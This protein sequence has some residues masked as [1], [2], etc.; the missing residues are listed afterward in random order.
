MFSF[1]QPP[2]LYRQSGLAL[3]LVL[4]QCW[5]VCMPPF[6][7]GIWVQTEPTICFLY[8]CAC[9][10]ALWLGVGAFKGWLTPAQG[11]TPL[12]LLMLGWIAWQI[13]MTCTA[14]LPYRSWFGPPQTGD[15]TGIAI[16]TL[17]TA[18][19]TCPVWQ[20]VSM[21]RIIL[22]VCAVS[23]FVQC[24]LHLIYPEVGGNPYMPD[25]W[26]PAQWP[27]YLPF[28]GAY[29]WVAAFLG[30]A[31]TSKKSFAIMVAAM[32][33][34]LRDSC[35][36]AA[37]GFFIPALVLSSLI[38]FLP[39]AKRVFAVTPLWR[40]LMIL[41][42]LLPF[43]LVIFS[44]DIQVG[45]TQS[46]SALRK[47]FSEMNEG[48]GSRV[49]LNRV[50]V[51]TIQNE[52][53]RM[54]FGNGWGTFSDD[55]FRYG[56][57]PD[58]YVY[59]NGERVPN[60]FLI[61]GSSHH[62]HNQPLE[63]LL[64]LG[65]VGLALWY[66]FYAIALMR[67]PEAQFWSVA[68]MLV[69]LTGL[70]HFWFPLPQCFAYQG[71]FMGVLLVSCGGFKPLPSVRGQ[72]MAV[73]AVM[74]AVVMGLSACAKWHAMMHADSV[75]K[76]IL[77]GSY[78]DHTEEWLGEDIARGG[79]SWATSARFYATEASSQ[80]RLDDNTLGW[81][82]Y[83]LHNAHSAA[84]NSRI[85]PHASFLELRIEYYLFGG[86]N[87]PIFDS[88]RHEATEAF[89]NSAIRMTHKAPLRDDQISFFLI[90]L[91]GLTNNNIEREEHIL[92]RLLAVA[93]HHRSC[94]WLLGNIYM[95]MPS[96]EELGRALL[97]EAIVTHVEKIYPITDAQIA[98]A[99]KALGLPSR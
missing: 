72:V 57:V 43:S 65:A 2:A 69:A 11:C 79:D 15:G 18:L 28:I 40:W 8:I 70:G 93:P 71:L 95:Q 4:L 62:S 77:Y 1:A 10:S 38:V 14:I 85:G 59:K 12:L 39:Q 56:L 54:V 84:Q 41:G 87:N 44:N 33:V 73:F 36:K 26:V 35:N 55:L 80:T 81:F 7:T 20:V 29:L 5:L 32:L 24:V 83:F 22:I 91:P 61:D 68:P 52:P 27:E 25:R 99:S 21:R 47:I 92:N 23:Y 42:C 67:L 51:M 90:N 82:T 89:E 30:G 9:L 16:A 94:L 17:L 3:L 37:G 60:W 46:H 97:K 64:S 86:F 49:L 76:A 58:T 66:G 31:I 48:F 88:L 63:A 75:H 19:L 45:N 78:K 96:K 74:A 6:Q 34:M 53:E 50:G 98:E 13:V